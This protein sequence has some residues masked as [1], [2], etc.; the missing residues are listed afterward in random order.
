M[1]KSIPDQHMPSHLMTRRDVLYRDNCLL[2]VNKPAGVPVHG[3][4]ILED[5][6]ETLLSMVREL[7]GNM[8]HAVHRL[9]RPVSGANL[10]T[11]DKVTLAGL[12][13][14]FE[15]RLIRKKW[16]PL[17]LHCSL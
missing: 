6:P 13:A 14:L 7:T 15:Q 12:G 5:N 1:L 16:G 4:R 3:G 17:V 9:D 11:F 2:I 10:L 8:V